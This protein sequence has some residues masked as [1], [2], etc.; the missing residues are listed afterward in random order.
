MAGQAATWAFKDVV[1]IQS[2]G[3]VSY[4]E[5]VNSRPLP[6]SAPDN[7]SG[8]RARLQAIGHLNDPSHNLTPILDSDEPVR[9]APPIPI[10][11]WGRYAYWN[12]QGIQLRSQGK[13]SEAIDAF[14][15]AIDL[16][17]TQPT[18]YLN[19]AMTAAEKQQY[20]LADRMF[21][22]ALELGLPKAEQ[23]LVDFA[24]F[25][26][27]RNLPARA[28]T[29]LYAG[30]RMFPRSYLIAANLGAYLVAAGRYP[31]GIPELERAL[32]LQPSSTA[33]LNNL[34]VAYVKE[35][36]YARALDFWNRSLAIDPRQ[37]E[38]REAVVAAR[39]RL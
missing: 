1:P 37:P 14:D 3:V 38:I 13:A 10:E 4:S 7:P 32:G 9:T 21:L 25:Y 8:Y 12:N 15:R 20:A 36:D 22:K 16:N 35:E 26:R 2:V 33:V 39:T 17:P 11:R 5:F 31:D 34:G 27:D 29:L 18:P 23:W 6:A 30:K 28:I 24:A 19:E